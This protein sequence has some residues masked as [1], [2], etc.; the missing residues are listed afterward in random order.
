MYC[1]TSL[2]LFNILFSACV[3]ILI[4]CLHFYFSV[5]LCCVSLSVNFCSVCV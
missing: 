3:I 4:E 5:N 2:H 1:E